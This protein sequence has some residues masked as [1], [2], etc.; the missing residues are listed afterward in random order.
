MPLRGPAAWSRETRLLWLTIAVSLGVLFVLAQFRFPT[1]DRPAPAPQP[2][3]RLA[4][5]A[6]YDELA[7]DV[8]RLERRLA[9]SLVVL[10]TQMPQRR[11]PR[12]LQQ[13]L[14]H[15]TSGMASTVY[16]PALRIR[17]DTAVALLA[18]S[19]TVEGVVGRDDALPLLV[20]TD[21]MRRLAVVR[22]P[23][24]PSGIGWQVPQLES[25]SSPRYLVTAEG[26]RGGTRLR[27]VFLG[28]AD[29]FEEPRWQTPL[30]QFGETP[31]SVAGALVFSLDGELAGLL[32]EDAGM[33]AI[34]PGAAVTAAA[35]ALLDRGAPPVTDFGLSLRPL[36]AADVKA[37]NVTSGLVVDN[38]Q[39]KSLAD[40]KLREG[41][42]LLAIDDVPAADPDSV[43]V[44]LARARPGATLRFRI[45]RKDAIV[46]VEIAVPNGAPSLGPAR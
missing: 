44:A 9:S 28:R 18:P 3:E 1:E 21:A 10:R 40:G 43:L 11:E 31:L 29:R 2:L 7:A 22:V 38:V 5:R 12:T 36:G 4:A 27:P 33:L 46:D 17:S 19:A 41:D 32:V 8:A 39:A 25:L 30:L 34:V 37:L 24:P 13:L 35:E 23:E 14:D 20:A 26:S 6:T 45:R 15:G 16:V 42:L